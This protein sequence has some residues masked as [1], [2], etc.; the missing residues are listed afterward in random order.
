MN[1]RAGRI[2]NKAKLVENPFAANSF[3]EVSKSDNPSYKNY[4]RQDLSDLPKEFSWL[5]YLEEPR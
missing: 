1:S 2:R 5:E 4:S 3:V